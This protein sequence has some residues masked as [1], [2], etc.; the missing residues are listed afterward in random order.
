MKAAG[1]RNM[2]AL[3]LVALAVGSVF[4][5]E[6]RVAASAVQTTPSANRLLRQIAVIDLPGPPGKRFDYLT[7][8]YPDHYLLSNHLGAGILYIIDTRTNKL[9]KAIPDVPGAE[10]VVAIPE[11]HRAY[12]ADWHENKVAAI[13]LQSMTIITKLPTRDKPDGIAYAAPFHKIYVSDERGH[14]E[15]VIDV[16]SNTV[17]NTLTFDSETGNV[18]YDEVAKRIYV[19]LQD[20]N[21]IAV[22]DPANDSVVAR[23]PVAGC[24]GN[25]GM[26]LD[27]EHRR[28]FISCEENDTM[29]AFDLEKHATI[30]HLP[31][32]GGADVIAF[33]PGLRRI[34]VA[35][36]SGAIS[37]FQQ[38]DPDHYRKLADFPVQRRV[39]SLAV[40]RE[41][42]RVYA[43]EEQE[44][45]RPVAKMIVFEAQ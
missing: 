18:V 44:D 25:H 35:C 1:W 39:H 41:T 15:T 12:T 34:Y 38:D 33:D 3:A 40:D 9:V 42:H 36:G 28:A 43:P 11:L 21:V 7:I 5:V 32:A 29:A 20:Q 37:I 8:D 22:I 24:K 45:G 31:M 27:A 13:D 26:A 4:W 23:W 2:A 10:G 16:N 19:N 17:V 6:A 14:A 30:A